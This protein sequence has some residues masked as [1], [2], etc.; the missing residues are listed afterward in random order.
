MKT[1]TGGLSLRCRPLRS[2]TRAR[3]THGLQLLDMFKDR[4]AARVHFRRRIHAARRRG[5]A[6]RL[7]VRQGA[8]PPSLL[9]HLRNALLLKRLGSQGR[10]D[11]GQRSLPGRSRRVVV[12]SEGVRWGESLGTRQ[13]QITCRQGSLHSSSFSKRLHWLQCGRA[14]FTPGQRAGEARPDWTEVTVVFERP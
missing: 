4:L 11:R 5:Q 8:Y 9:F 13:E 6:D 2:T 7:P 10:N 14:N 1:Y 12:R 3:G